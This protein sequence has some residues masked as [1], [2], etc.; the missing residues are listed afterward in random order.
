[1]S[2]PCRDVV[3]R[4]PLAER[5]PIRPMFPEVRNPGSYGEGKVPEELSSIL[6]TPR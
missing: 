5:P 4:R 2:P 6:L 3:N 1:V